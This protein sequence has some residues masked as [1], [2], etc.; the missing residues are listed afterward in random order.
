M[1]EGG[2][3]VCE[4]DRVVISLGGSPLFTETS[5]SI[6]LNIPSKKF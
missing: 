5:R 3:V 2:L 6:K 1:M 4:A